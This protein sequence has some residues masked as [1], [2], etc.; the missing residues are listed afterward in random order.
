MKIVDRIVMEESQDDDEK[1]R[2]NN[3]L[4][5]S[6]VRNGETCFKLPRNAAARRPLSM[7]SKTGHAGG[8]QPT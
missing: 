2:G 8:G 7:I 5:V 6:V 1:A 4:R 3:A